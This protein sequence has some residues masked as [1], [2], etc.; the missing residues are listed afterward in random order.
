MWCVRKM[1]IKELIREAN[2]LHEK[3]KR[4]KAEL[5]SILE[6]MKR[7]DRMDERIQEKLKSYWEKQLNK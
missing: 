7:L 1:K 3:K 6:T 5:N 2:E 4:V